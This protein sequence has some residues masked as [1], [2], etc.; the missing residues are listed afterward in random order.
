MGVVLASSAMS[1]RA[2]GRHDGRRVGLGRVDRH[3]RGC[4]VL[5]RVHRRLRAGRA[6]CLDRHL[7]RLGLQLGVHAFPATVVVVVL[8]EDL[9]VGVL[10]LPPE[11]RK[12]IPTTILHV[13]TPMMPLRICLR[14]FC[15]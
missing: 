9:G 12:T 2:G 1:K 4:R 13:T 14:R 10:V 3:S 6:A 8:A 7:V 5:L 15:L 11:T